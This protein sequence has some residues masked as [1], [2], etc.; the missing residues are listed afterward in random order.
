MGAPAFSCMEPSPEEANF[1][2]YS[3]HEPG[4][5]TEAA[6]DPYYTSVILTYTP[7][8]GDKLTVTTADG[9]TFSITDNQAGKYIDPTDR[10]LTRRLLTGYNI[11]C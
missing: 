3:E 6:K 5:N 11:V 9:F 8:Q 7:G 4:A 1:L 2:P 10:V